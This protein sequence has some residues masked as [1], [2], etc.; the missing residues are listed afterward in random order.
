MLAVLTSTGVLLGLGISVVPATASGPARGAASVKPAVT[1]YHVRSGI[2]TVRSSSHKKLKVSI[3]ASRQT[4]SYAKT[5]KTHVSV[6]VWTPSGSESHTWRF[7]A[8]RSALGFGSKTGTIKLPK[9]NVKPYGTI[10]LAFKRLGDWRETKCDDALMS[11]YAKVKVSGTFL[12]HTRS[13]GKHKWGTLGS[14]KTPFHFTT[15]GSQMKR[16]YSDDNMCEIDYVAPAPRGS[17]GA[18]GGGRTIWSTTPTGK[19]RATSVAIVR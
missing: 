2:T 17:T 14:A 18:S 8:P 7:Q 13:T 5:R 6:H 19:R 9:A 11:N 4:Q 16:S 15:S 3:H 10:R 1:N 12:F